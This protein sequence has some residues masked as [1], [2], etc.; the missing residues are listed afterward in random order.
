MSQQTSHGSLSGRVAVVTGSGR[1]IG[2]A[3]AM[4]LAA[5]CAAVVVNARTSQAQVDA[6]VAEIKALGGQA[7]GCLADVTQPDD[8][9]RM[10]NLAVE[11]F[12][13]LDILVNNAAV[14]REGKLETVTLEAWREILS[15]ILDGA[16]L[17]AQAASAHMIKRGRGAIVNIGGMTGSSGASHRPHV[18]SA[19]A[20]LVGLTK[21]LAWD[22]AEHQITSNLVSPGMIETERDTSTVAAKPKHH[23][24]HKPLLE[25]RGTPEEVASVVQMLCGPDGQF[26]TGQVV[27]VNG[28]AYLN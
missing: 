6:V 25:R 5:E 28:G 22:L 21:S 16:F 1:N 24:I 3:I 13:G 15:I 2:K 20:G 23:A 11:Q 18:V 19:K 9:T 27:H 17:C 8:V 7:V 4:R 26:V 10:M 12:G 14:R